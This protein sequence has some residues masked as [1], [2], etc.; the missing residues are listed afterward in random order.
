MNH[1]HYLAS[2][3]RTVEACLIGTGEFGRS[4]LAQ[5]LRVPSMRARVAVD[6]DSAA[7]AKAF[8]AVGVP[9]AEVAL[10]TTGAEARTA[11]DAGRF[12]AT[13][14]LA[15]ALDLPLDIVVEATGQ[16]EAGARHARMAIEAGKHLALV[17][18]EV[19]SVAGP[20]LA[21]LARQSGLVVTPIDGDQPSLLIDLVTWAERLGFTIVAA[22][23]SSEYDFVHDERAGTITSNGRTIDAPGLA[24]LWQLG[25]TEVA[26]FVDLRS[27]AVAALPQRTVPDL[28]ELLLVANA[29]GLVPDRPDLHAPIARIS[30]IPTVFAT[31][32]DGGLMSGVGRIDVFNCLR[33]RDEIS[34]AGGVFVV[35]RCDYAETWRVLEA[36]GHIVSRTGA[37]AL[38]YTP[39]HLLGLEA[40][41]S[42]LSAALRGVSTGAD[43]PEPR[44]DLMARADTDLPAG[45]MLAAVGHHHSIA[46]VSGLAMPGTR[47]GPDAPVPY[48]LAANRRLARAVFRG[49]LIT[50][51]DLELTG[52]SALLKLRHYQDRAFFGKSVTGSQAC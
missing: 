37:T 21:H 52:D 20:G 43:V 18:K 30:E 40:A 27:K 3:D 33:R 41:T 44:F 31:R 34:F 14:E 2:P 46:N 1:L 22:G 25:D 48:Y 4:F 50:G 6:R 28:C 23:K 35:I 8:A 13:G 7:A 45:T 12:I 38:V 32:E 49:T 39:R 16:P 42:I 19:D 36:K 29:T 26:A 15:V 17:S 9:A 11:W 10:C 5:G 24:E 51:D 47:L